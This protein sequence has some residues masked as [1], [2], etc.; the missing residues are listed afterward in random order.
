[1]LTRVYPWLTSL[2]WPPGACRQWAWLAVFCALPALAAPP[3]SPKGELSEVRDRIKSL[4]KEVESTE[5]AKADASDALKHSEQAISAANRKLH[6]LA[7]Q[8]RETDGELS[9]LQQDSGKTRAGIAEQQAQLGKLLTQL[10]LHGQHD[11]LEILLSRQDPNQLARH[12]RY[13]AEVSRARAAAIRDLRGDLRHLGELTAAEKKKA[14]EL[15]QIKAEQ[16]TQ[17]KR[18]EKE[19]GTRKVLLAKLSQKIAAQRHEIGKLQNDEKRL[20]RLIEKLNRLAAAKAAKEAKPARGRKPSET[21]LNTAIPTPEDSGGPFRQLKGK[22]HLPIK[23]ELANRFGTPRE[24]GGVT[25]KGLFIRAASGQPVKAVANGQIVF[26]DWLRGFGNI[27]I[28]DHG[29]SFMSLYGN[30]ETLYKQAGETVKAGDTVASVGNSGGI[31]D[32][33][34]YFELRYQSKPFDPLTWVSLK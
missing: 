31:P 14:A 21:V 6:A 22:L 30:N 13:Y 1:M 25:W 2:A 34:L 5:D 26:S 20:T 27:I 3:S 4:Q 23:G 33:G 16:A 10:Y 19:Q 29:S 12:L 15:A 8:Q 32:S 28:I 7:Q 17:K 24:D 9:R 18:L 11:Y